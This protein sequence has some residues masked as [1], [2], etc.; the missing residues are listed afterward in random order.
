LSNTE[1]SF[2]FLLALTAVAL[3]AAQTSPPPRRDAQ[4]AIDDRIR[5]LQKESSDLARQS[6]TLLGELRQ[7]EI[8]RDL[9]VHEATQAQAASVDAQQALERATARLAALEAQRVAQLPDLRKQLVDLYKRGRGGY[10]RLLANASGL[11]DFSRT[12][13]AVA[14]LAT[15]NERRV[16]EHRRTLE[17]LAAERTALERSA[18]DLQ[19]REATARQA[20][21]AAERA[22]TARAALIARIDSRRDLTAQYVGELQV[23]YDRLQQL[24]ATAATGPAGGTISVP[25]EPFRGALEWP[26]NGRVSGRFGQS[27]SRLGGTAVRNGI[28]IAAAEDAPVRAVHRGTVGYADVFT[29]LG[30][31]VILDHGRNNYSMYG[32]LGTMSVERG[33]V[34]DAGAELGRVGF[35]PAGPPALYFEMRIDGR[36]VDPLQWLRQR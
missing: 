7:L 35:A 11:R 29:G 26:V 12:M 36:S 5:A 22:V 20:R 3:T 28:E 24:T 17:A 33:A 10:T 15:I 19:A 18:A 34:V 1:R 16:T 27:S 8:E 25:L 6:Q 4:G 2:A 13:R 23:A 21:E 14:A 32:Y 9:R 31:L 30:N